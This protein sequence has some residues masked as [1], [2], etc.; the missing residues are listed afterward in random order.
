MTTAICLLSLLYGYDREFVS[1]EMLSRH[2]GISRATV[3]KYVK[4]LKE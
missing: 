3:S 1:G 4:I 2:L